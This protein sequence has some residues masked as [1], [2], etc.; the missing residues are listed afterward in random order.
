MSQQDYF[1]MGTKIYFIADD[2]LVI[3][4]QQYGKLMELLPVQNW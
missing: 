3:P 2:E 4:G 1:A